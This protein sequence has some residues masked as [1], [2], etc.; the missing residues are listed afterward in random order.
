M[1]WQSPPIFPLLKNNQIH[2]WR[3]ILERDKE[4]LSELLNLLN[5]QEKERADKFMVE[6]AKNNF[7]IARGSLRQLLAKYLQTTPQSLVFQQNKYGK[8]FLNTS[9][10]QSSIQFN[11]SHSRNFALFIF[12]LNHPVG[13]DIEYIRNDSGFELVNTAQRFFSTT[14]SAIIANLPSKQQLSAFFNCWSRKEAVIKAIGDGVFFGLDKFSVEISNKKEGR[15]QLQFAN[16]KF[17]KKGWSLE[18]LDPA[19]G[20]TGAF[21]TPLSEYVPNFYNLCY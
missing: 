1:L 15:L 5:S 19:V 16:D 17:N 9:M 8:L 11:I 12:T 4:K 7:I 21:A 6:H 20:Y 2:I 14:E 10:Q 13:I 18:A 3:T